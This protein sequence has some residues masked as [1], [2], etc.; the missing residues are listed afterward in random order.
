MCD[1]NWC[2]YCDCAVSPYSNSI[3]CSEDC[4]KR[5][6][7]TNHP[8]FTIFKEPQ[9]QLP[10][11][12]VLSHIQQEYTPSSSRRA[13]NSS[14]SSEDLLPLHFDM[15]SSTTPI[16]SYN[17]FSNFVSSS[18]NINN[19]QTLVTNPPANLSDNMPASRKQNSSLLAYA[20]HNNTFLSLRL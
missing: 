18:L 11:N 16:K 2:T 12:L 3:Y 17:T 14:I 6:A 5:D 20:L 19:T 15:M 9:Q 4:F 1:T 7:L 10:S 13:S 8:L